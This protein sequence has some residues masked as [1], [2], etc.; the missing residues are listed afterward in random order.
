MNLITHLYRQKEFSENTFGPGARV[1]GV[2]DHIAKELEE[3]RKAPEDLM[4]WI[5]VVLL[6]LDG[7]WRAGY[8]P[9]EIVAAIEAKQTKNEN[10]KWPDWK[11]ADPTKAIEHVRT[12]LG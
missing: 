4:E 10:R 8:S 3:I 2:L 12:D 1:V 11:T 6:S 7:A 9:E 5:D